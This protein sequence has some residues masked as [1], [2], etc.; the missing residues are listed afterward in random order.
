MLALALQLSQVS[1]GGYFY[2]GRQPVFVS[3]GD[4]TQSER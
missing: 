3:E 4:L 1:L 2:F